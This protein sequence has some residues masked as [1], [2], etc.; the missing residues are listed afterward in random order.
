MFAKTFLNFVKSMAPKQFY[1]SFCKVT[2]CKG[3]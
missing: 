2:V 3:R 1:I